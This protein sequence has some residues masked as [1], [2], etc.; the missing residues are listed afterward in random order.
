MSDPEVIVV[1]S[2]PNGLAAAITMAREGYRVLVL[3]AADT[4]GG[5]ARTCELTL[6][7]FRHDVCSAIHPL[8]MASPFLNKLGLEAHGLEWI[9]PPVPVAHPLHGGRVVALRRSLEETAEA[10]GPDGEPY[11][12]LLRPLVE[13]WEDLVGRFLRPLRPALYSRAALRFAQAAVRSAEGL[14]RRFETDDAKALVAGL[15]GHAVMPLDRS[16]SASVG[17]VLALLGHAVGWPFPRGGS[18]RLADAMAAI[19]RSHGGTIETGRR[20][21]SLDELPPA[22]AVLLDVTPAQIL[23]IAGD[24][25]PSFYRRQLRSFRYGPGV[26]KI[27]LALD[28]PVPWSNAL[29]R[30]TACVHVGGSFDEIADGEAR[31][32]R[33]EHPERP[34]VLV[35]Q[36]SLFDDSRA[37]A[38]KQVVWAYCHVPN[39]ST[40]DMSPRIEAQIERFAPGFRDRILARHVMLPAELERRN[41]NLLGGDI[42][43]GAQTLWQLFARPALRWNPYTTPL[44]G[45]YVCSSSTPPGGGVHGMCGHLAAR[46]ALSAMEG[47]DEA[48]PYH[49]PAKLADD[50]RQ[51]RLRRAARKS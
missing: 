19:L 22:R 2:G 23:R 3:E 25:L 16:P 42:G 28:G 29:C 30:D 13:A 49:G 6:P 40:I 32:W 18:Q 47:A 48:P 9:E 10:L 41:E 46:A 44:P 26:C 33:G 45:V 35:A 21:R 15:A 43:G 51:A 14:C 27:D 11:E 31:V 8:A 50:S 1:G 20:V 38:G 5:G 12:D 7:G 36:N 17:I 37:P 4:Y 39:G 24:R 34:F